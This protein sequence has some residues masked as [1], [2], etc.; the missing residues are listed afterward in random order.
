ML[1]AGPSYKLSDNL[2]IIIM[3]G[4]ITEVEADAIVNAANSYLSHG[5][6]V[7][8]AIV[9]KGGYEIQ[10]ES[11]EY[12]RK[13]GPVPV[14]DVAVTGAGKLKAKY[15][16]HAVGPRYG[17]EEDEK[18]ESAIKRSLEKAEELNLVSIAFP[19][20]ST[21]IYGYPYHIC[22]K[23]MAKVFKNYKARKLRKIIVVLYDDEAFSVFKNVFDR[24]FT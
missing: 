14:G 18:L 16:I 2:E 15:I 13:F 24:S 20:I 17:I 1:T 23:I 3:K 9:K 12:V 6:G 19:A 10:K 21:G 8:Y 4:D 11:D 5:G 7:A 22:A